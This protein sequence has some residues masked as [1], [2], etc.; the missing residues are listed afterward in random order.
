[1]VVDRGFVMIT[2]VIGHLWTKGS[3]VYAPVYSF[4][5]VKEAKLVQLNVAYSVACDFR[6]INHYSDS[7]AKR[8]VCS[9]CF[10]LILKR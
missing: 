7:V 9:V 3:K 4:S 2:L 1:M 10:R 5:F 6:G 8:F